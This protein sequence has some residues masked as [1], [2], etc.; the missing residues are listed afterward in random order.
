MKE[1]VEDRGGED[2]VAEDG[3]HSVK[4]LLLVMIVE[5]FS[6][7]RLISWKN[8]LA[9]SRSRARYPTSSMTS[10]DG[11]MRFASCRGAGLLR[12]RL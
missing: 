12:R 9:S 1:S 2:V 6:Y 8:M 7:L 3:S 5:P 4:C 10:R 11:R